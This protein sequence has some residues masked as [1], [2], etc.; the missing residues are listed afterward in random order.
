MY[1]ARASSPCS[2][3]TELGL[4]AAEVVVD[5]AIGIERLQVLCPAHCA[6]VCWS[7]QSAARL[8]TRRLACSLDEGGRA[9]TI[10]TIH[11][12]GTIEA[13]LGDRGTARVRR[14]F[15]TTIV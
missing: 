13:H 8:L 15:A 6:S 9:T 11:A 12:S 4:A 10:L 2:W 14:F 7:T 5:H 1:E 3:D